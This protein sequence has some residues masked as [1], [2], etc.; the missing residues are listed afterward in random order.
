MN[1][2]EIVGRLTR[3]PEVRYSTGDKPSATAK[4]SVAVNRK[5]KNT[6]GNYDA[7]FINCVAFG[8]AGEFI[9]K[10][11]KKGMAIGLTGRIQTGNYTNKKGDKVYTTDII[12]E[13]SEFVESKGSNNHAT[14]PATPNTPS[15]D[16]GFV[17]IPDSITEDLP[18]N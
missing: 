2:V 9:E 13:D 17:N 7:D 4:F 10:Y 18:F 6:D 15:N 8:K 3:D 14:Q 5:F 16:D 1:K 12:V 11:F